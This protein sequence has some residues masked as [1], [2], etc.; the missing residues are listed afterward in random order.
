MVNKYKNLVH[1]VFQVIIPS[2]EDFNNSQK[3]LIMS[4]V[5][6]INNNHLFREK[7]YWVPLTNFASKLRR[8]WKFIYHV[9]R[10]TM[11]QS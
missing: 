6:R 8:V 5:P 3:L 1:A 10:K 2:F 7:D 11:I 9:T 4:F